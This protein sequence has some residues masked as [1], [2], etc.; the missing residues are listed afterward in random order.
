MKFVGESSLSIYHRIGI[1]RK[2]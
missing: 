1:Y 2:P